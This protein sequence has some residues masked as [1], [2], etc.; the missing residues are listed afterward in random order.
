MPSILVAPDSFKGTFSA[1]EVAG[2]ISAGI[3]EQGLTAIECPLAD[4]GE[5]TL[6]VLLQALHGVSKFQFVPGPFGEGVDARWGWVAEQR[7]AI[8][9][10]AQVC[11]LQFSGLT[12]TDALHATTAGVGELLI[13]AAEFGAVK[14]IVAMGGSATTDGGLGAIHVL[15]G[16]EGAFAGI[17]VEVLADV[18]VNFEDCAEIFAPQKGADPAT[19]ALLSDR[20]NQVA[21]IYEKRYGKDPRGRSQLGAAGGLSGGLWAALD[22]TVFSGAEYILDL[23]GFVDLARSANAVVLGEGKLDAQSFLGKI[24]GVAA[25]RV[26]GR[27]VI[28]VVGSTSLDAD[29]AAA[30]GLS[31]VLL[32]TDPSELRSSGNRVSEL[33]S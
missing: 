1:G 2:Y 32:A 11:G 31:H 26:H 30:W 29:Q 12:P 23:V 15:E 17:S 10:V 13:A 8:I 3:T 21:E 4:G 16:R 25:G 18:T 24:V 5:G 14:I 6:D 33:L 19:V 20:L 7:L 27:P 9:E 28:A 22:A